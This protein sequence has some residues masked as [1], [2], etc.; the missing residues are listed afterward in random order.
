MKRLLFLFVLLLPLSGKTIAIID[1]T[2]ARNSSRL[3][4]LLSS[5]YEC[6]IYQSSRPRDLSTLTRNGYSHI[7]LYEPSAEDLKHPVAEDTLPRIV[8]NPPADMKDIPWVSLSTDLSSAAAFRDVGRL[9]ERDI[10]PIVLLYDSTHTAE[11]IREK[12]SFCHPISLIPVETSRDLQREIRTAG[13]GGSSMVRM[14]LRPEQ[15]SSWATKTS[16]TQTINQHISLLCTNAPSPW[17]NALPDIGHIQLRENTNLATTAQAFFSA[18]F[19]EDLLPPTAGKIHLNSSLAALS[20]GSITHYTLGGTASLQQ[21]T[22]QQSLYDAT[23]FP[24]WGEV[25]Q[26]F[27]DRMI[28]FPRVTTPSTQNNKASRH[29]ETS[30][31]TW[32]Q[33]A[34][35]LIRTIVL[36]P[37]YNVVVSILLACTLILLARILICRLRRTRRP[38]ALIFPRALRSQRM[39][40]RKHAPTIVRYFRQRGIHSVSPGSLISLDKMVQHRMPQFFIL[41]GRNK[42][43]LTYLQKKITRYQLSSAEI[44]L[45]F[46]IPPQYTQTVSHAFGMA[47]TLVYPSIPVEE[48]LTADLKKLDAQG[49]VLSGRIKD[50]GLSSVLQMLETQKESG[51]LVI[52]DESPVSIFYYETGRIVHGQDRLG[53]SGFEALFTGLSC[54][55]GTFRFISGKHAP[56]HTVN[57][58]SMELLLEYSRKYDEEQHA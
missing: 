57:L 28:V 51:C 54:T 11:A 14:L 7:I 43:A 50:T 45:I 6:S 33:Q 12:H 49:E 29:K 30:D 24:S 27:A 10:P 46:Y 38:V 41:D 23:P 47:T 39:G 13:E 48:D 2:P 55:C 37:Y 52:E 18:L 15:A 8:I 25:E 9:L 17:R 20:M 16:V 58:G 26:L 4:T 31:D 19:I 34:Y 40:T 3:Y 42:A 32:T 56:V 36:H 21:G 22:M 5:L 53:N 35:A 1:N 44:I